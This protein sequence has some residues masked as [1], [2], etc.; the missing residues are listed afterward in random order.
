MIELDVINEVLSSF[1]DSSLPS[2]LSFLLELLGAIFLVSNLPVGDL[3]FSAAVDLVCS[4]TF[5]TTY[6]HVE[7]LLWR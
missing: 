5:R 7:W 2:A 3:A 4:M 6:I 1:L